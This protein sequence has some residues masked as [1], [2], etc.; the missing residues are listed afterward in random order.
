MPW[1]CVSVPWSSVAEIPEG[2]PVIRP[3][4]GII[5]SPLADRYG[6]RVILTLSVPRMA[7]G[8]LI[9]RFTPRSGTIGYGAPILLLV[10]RVLQGIWAG[11]EQL[12]GFFGWDRALA[13]AA[14][15]GMLFMLD[16]EP[17]TVEHGIGEHLLVQLRLDGVAP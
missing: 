15:L 3:F 8:F 17:G 2:W 6:R 16:A 10:A 4:S 13:W 12:V 14:S 7:L 5:I 11:T 9:I 1:G